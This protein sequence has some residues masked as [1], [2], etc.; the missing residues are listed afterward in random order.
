[1]RSNCGWARLMNPDSEELVA[2]GRV[3]VS[4]PAQVVV[5]HDWNEDWQGEIDLLRPEGPILR[6]GTYALSFEEGSGTH[7]VRLRGLTMRDEPSGSYSH[8]RVL[9][10]DAFTPSVITELGGEE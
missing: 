9:G 2:R 1:M 4:S 7:L 3:F 6:D 5:T 10:T 8:G